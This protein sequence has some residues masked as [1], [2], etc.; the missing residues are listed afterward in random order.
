MFP[1]Y[2]R[3]EVS[4][5]KLSKEDQKLFGKA[6]QKEWNSWIENK[7][8]SLCKSKGISTEKVIKARW[9]LTWKKSSDP[10]DRTKTPRTRLVLVGCQDPDLGIIQADSPTLRKET[11]HL[12]LSL[13]AAKRWRICSADIK[14]AFLS[15]DPSSRDIFFNPPKEIKEW[16]SLADADLYRLEKAAYGLAEAP[17]AWF[18]R[19]SRELKSAGLTVS[20]LDPCLYSLRKGSKLL[21]VCGVHV[22]DLIGG[23]EP[24][25]DQVLKDLK[26]KLPFGD[27]RTYTIR[28]TGIEIR[29]CTNTHAIELGQEAYID[30]LEPV[31]T[32]SLCTASTPLTDAS[33]MRTCAG[34][35]AWVATSTRPDQ[36]FLAS[37][38]QGIQDKHTV[39]HVQMYN[40]AIRE[41]KE[42]KVC[43]RF[44]AGINIADWRI[45]CISDAGWGTRANG[46]SQGGYILCVTT[47]AMFERRRTTCWIIDWQSKKLCRVVC[48]CRNIGRTEWIGWYRSL[49]SLA[50]WN[51]S[52]HDP[53]GI[54]R[55]NPKRPS[56]VGHWLTRI[57][58]CCH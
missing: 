2:L 25:M 14:T 4:F 44:P 41:M 13:C 12:I 18:L 11:R 43:L 8:S 55:L 22:D 23:G 6:M 32:K 50:C 38:L 21:G 36:A 19:L 5:R 24:E 15:G 35:L 46:E 58:W 17:R 39:A 28:Y 37:Y 26:K 31:C 16:M 30:A 40:K 51:T 9:V 29:Q 49:S 3:V 45:L 53:K 33:I 57:L 42:R 27:Y 56:R 48:S 54:P 47:P 7:V 10:D 52:W 34:Q 1:S 20:Q